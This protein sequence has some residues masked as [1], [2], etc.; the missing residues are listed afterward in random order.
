M[1][2]REI[3][4]IGKRIAVTEMPPVTQKVALAILDVVRQ[5]VLGDHIL[6]P[7]RDEEEDE[8]EDEDEEGNSSDSSA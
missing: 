7:D 6:F 2:A 5:E 1:N 3:R 8:D 4:L